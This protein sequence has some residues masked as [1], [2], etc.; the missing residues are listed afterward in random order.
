MKFAIW[1]LFALTAYAA[2]SVAV[3]S[4][5]MTEYT[6]LIPVVLTLLYMTLAVA[7]VVYGNP[8][9]RAFAIGASVPLSFLLAVL[10]FVYGIA[11]IDGAGPDFEVPILRWVIGTAWLLTIVCGVVVVK[12]KSPVN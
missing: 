9:T 10:F 5:E 8:S 2:V 11:V 12:I 3:L 4:T 6:A 1:Q 7:F